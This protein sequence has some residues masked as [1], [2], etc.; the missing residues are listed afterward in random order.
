MDRVTTPADLP[1]RCPACGWKGPAS[2]A[3]FFNQGTL[4]CPHCFA[5]A[6]RDRVRLSFVWSLFLRWLREAFRWRSR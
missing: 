1:C 2:E 3:D 4:H 6:G 5:P